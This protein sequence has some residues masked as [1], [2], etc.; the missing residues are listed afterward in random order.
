MLCGCNNNTE[1]DLEPKLTSQNSINFKGCYIYAKT[2]ILNDDVQTG[3]GTN[4]KNIRNETIKI[5]DNSMVYCK[6]VNDD[7]INCDTINLSYKNN[8]LELDTED[9]YFFNK[10]NVYFKKDIFNNYM[11]WQAKLEPPDTMNVYYD[12]TYCDKV[13]SLKIDELEI[14]KD[15]KGYYQIYYDD[16]PTNKLL[17]IG[18]KILTSSYSDNFIQS[19]WN[20]LLKDNKIIYSQKEINENNIYSEY[21]Y[22]VINNKIYIEDIHGSV[23][24]KITEEDYNNQIKIWDK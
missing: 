19:E 17:Y 6:K 11:I 8:T 15:L 16:T 12:K 10:Y 20:Y 4:E 24:V 1:T 21:K 2:I 14:K 13:E 5:K 23:L 7:T 18:T 9:T 22:K 3:E